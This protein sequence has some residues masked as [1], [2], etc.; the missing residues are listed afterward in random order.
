[1]GADFDE[2]TALVAS[3]RDRRSVLGLLGSGAV[4]GVLGLR[5]PRGAGK[6]VAASPACVVQYPVKNLNDCPNKRPHPGYKPTV[7]GCGPAGV[8]NL[9]LWAVIPDS[10]GAVNMKPACD[11]H[12]RCYGTCNSDKQKCDTN[13]GDQIFTACMAVYPT[14]VASNGVSLNPFDS[15]WQGICNS[16]GNTYAQAVS[17]SSTGQAAFDDAQK[18]A[19]EC[20]FPVQYV[21][22]NCNQKCYTDV[23][24]CLQD[25]TVSLGCFT[26]ICG[27]ATASQ[28]P[29]S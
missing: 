26:G 11:E 22:C 5:F 10:I 9:P 23:N 21:Y 1:M 12:D 27:P 16:L 18:E 13:L 8:I 20:C 4:A 6:K 19:C 29:G 28:C 17:E 15:F 2:F 25:C 7:N 24:V 3:Q 14:P